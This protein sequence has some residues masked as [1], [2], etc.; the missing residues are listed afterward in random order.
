MVTVSLIILLFVESVVCSPKHSTSRLNEALTSDCELRKL[1]NEYKETHAHTR[2]P[3]E[4]RVRFKLFLEE[5]KEI[6]ELQNNP[7]ITWEVGVNFMADMT[8]EEEDLMRGTVALNTSFSNIQ[9]KKL[10]A[11]DKSR[12]IPKSSLFWYSK[13]T[14][15]PI[16]QQLKGSCWAH[17]AAAVIDAQLTARSGT[18]HELS[19]QELYDCTDLGHS[20]ELGGDAYKAFEYVKESNH[21]NYALGSPETNAKRGFN[22]NHHTKNLNALKGYKIDKV[23]KLEKTEESLLYHVHYVSPVAVI[24]ETKYS[25]LERYRGGIYTGN[26]CGLGP[27]H[28]V[29]VVAYDEQILLIRNSWGKEWG[30]AGY[31]WWNRFGSKCSILEAM[32]IPYLVPEE[33]NKDW[34][35]PWPFNWNQLK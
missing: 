25:Q 24:I 5:I 31:L 12:E 6:L 19:V 30:N 29:V 11:V 26:L 2:P 34:S 17:A 23:E 4:E 27:D 3:H 32:S 7:D 21:L 15:G 9:R 28:A 35:W 20:K 10:N 18:F 8:E 33:K 1:Y 13:N 14:M 22:C 16:R